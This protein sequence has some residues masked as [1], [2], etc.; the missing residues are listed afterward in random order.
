MDLESRIQELKD[1]SSLLNSLLIDFQHL[2]QYTPQVLN[3]KGQNTDEYKN[4]CVS[5]FKICERVEE[6]SKK[7]KLLIPNNELLATSE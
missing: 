4:L 3:Y 6:G 2:E 5:L 7:V 1:K